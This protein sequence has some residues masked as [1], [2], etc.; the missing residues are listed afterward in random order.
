MGGIERRVTRGT[1]EEKGKD[2]EMELGREELD[3]IIKKLNVG[4]AP[5]EIVLQTKYKSMGA[6]R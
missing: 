6:G 1:R 3:R 5:W 2:G 4:K